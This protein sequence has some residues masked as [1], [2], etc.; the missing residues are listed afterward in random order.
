MRKTPPQ[1]SITLQVRIR[2]FDN[3]FLR[4]RDSRKHLRYLE[5]KKALAPEEKKDLADLQRYDTY[6]DWH[7]EDAEQETGYP[8]LRGTLLRV[9]ALR[10]LRRFL[11]QC[12][13]NSRKLIE[14]CCSGERRPASEKD[15]CTRHH[16]C[17]PD[18]TVGDRKKSDSGQSAADEQNNICSP[19][20]PC[21]LCQVTGNYDATRVHGS[22][23]FNP[24]ADPVSVEF[25]RH[26]SPVQ[27]NGFN[28]HEVLRNRVRNHYDPRNGT[29]R[30]YFECM[31]VDHYQCADFFG[32]ITINLDRGYVLKADAETIKM[33]LAVGL[34]GITHLAGAPCRIDIGHSDKDK[35]AGWDFTCHQSLLQQFFAT[36]VSGKPIPLAVDSPCP[37]TIDYNPL[38]RDAASSQIDVANPQPALA[39]SRKIENKALE[40]LAAVKNR[41]GEKGSGS[42]LMDVAATLK[43]IKETGINPYDLPQQK[44]RSGTTTLW[45][46]TDDDGKTLADHLGAALESL[47]KEP[48]LRNRFLDRA[49]TLLYNADPRVG[50][51]TSGGRLFRDNRLI[52]PP[53]PVP[54]VAPPP[55]GLNNWALYFITGYLE[56]KSPFHFGDTGSSLVGQTIF[57]DGE[58]RLRLP[59]TTQRGALDESLRF[60]VRGCDRDAGVD[61]GPCPVC[62]LMR[63][64][65]PEPSRLDSPEVSA[66]FRQRIRIHS[67]SGTVANLFATENGPEGVKFPFILRYDEPDVWGKDRSGHDVPCSNFSKKLKELL[68]LWQQGQCFLGGNWGT[69]NGR[70]ALMDLLI[71]KLTFDNLADYLTCRSL[72]GASVE[73]VRGFF[74][75][76]KI[77]YPSI[78]LPLAKTQLTEIEYILEFHSPLLV[79]DPASARIHDDSPDKG[80]YFKQKFIGLKEDGS[81]DYQ[82]VACLPGS[83]IRGPLSTL[84]GRSMAA[85]SDDH[86]GC[87]CVRCRIFGNETGR[88]PLRFDD[89]ECPDAPEPTLCDHVA[90]NT[91]GGSANQKKFDD[92][93]LPG[94]PG[95]GGALVFKGSMWLRGDLDSEAWNALRNAFIDLQNNME[96]IGANGSIGYGWVAKV[97]FGDNAPEKVIN[98]VRDFP[99]PWWEGR[100]LA[101]IQI[102]GPRPKNV[103]DSPSTEALAT[104]A[105]DGKATDLPLVPKAQ[106]QPGKKYW[107]KYYVPPHKTVERLSPVGHDRWHD[108]R[109]SGIIQCELE[110]KSPL[111]IPD[112]NDDRALDVPLP[113]LGDLAKSNLVASF[114]P[115]EYLDFLQRY[116]PDGQRQAWDAA[117][118]CKDGSWHLPLKKLTSEMLEQ[119]GG[120]YELM[121]RTQHKSRKFFELRDV[122]LPPASSIRGMV[123]AVLQILT[124][125]CYRNLEEKH[126]ITRRMSADEIKPEKAGSNKY[127]PGRIA[128]VEADGSVKIQKMTSLRLPLYDDPVTTNNLGTTQA[129]CHCH[130][131]YNANL[132]QRATFLNNVRRENALKN[133][134][135]IAAVAVANRTFLSKLKEKDQSKFLKIIAGQEPVYFTAD[136]IN[137]IENKK[138]KTKTV[139]EVAKL[140]DKPAGATP[141]YIKLTGPNNAM[142]KNDAT[143]QWHD[144]WSIEAL[145]ILLTDSE[146]RVSNSQTFPRPALKAAIDGRQ[147]TISKR[148]ERIFHSGDGQYTADA[149]TVGRYAETVIETKNNQEDLPP[150]FRTRLPN[151]DLNVGDLIYFK[152]LENGVTKTTHI[153]PVCISRGHDPLPL[154]KRLPGGNENLRPCSSGCLG[155]CEACDPDTFCAFFS[156]P[157]PD[158]CPTCSLLGTTSHR[159]RLRFGIPEPIFEGTKPADTCTLVTLP[160]RENP[161]YQW[162][163]PDSKAALPGRPVYVN[164]PHPEGVLPVQGIPAVHNQT[165]APLPAGRRF[166]FP[167]AFTNLKEWE[168]GILLFA[169]ELAEGCAQRLGHGKDLGLGSVQIRVY[170]ILKREQKKQDTDTS[171][172]SCLLEKGNYLGK[173]LKQLEEW[174]DAEKK[175]NLE[176][177]HINNLLHLLYIPEVVGGEEPAGMISNPSL[178]PQGNS[179]DD[180]CYIN[181]RK[182]LTSVQIQARQSTPWEPW[183]TDQSSEPCRLRE[184]RLMA[185][186]SGDSSPRRSDNNVTT[187]VSSKQIPSQK[188][189]E[190]REQC[191][192]HGTPRASDA[193]RIIETQQLLVR[194]FP[195]EWRE[196]DINALFIDY[197]VTTGKVK[198]GKESR[199]PYINVSIKA[200][201]ADKA[202]KTLNGKNIPGTELCLEVCKS[203]RYLKAEISPE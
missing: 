199:L 31:E 50:Q 21:P 38:E 188:N 3:P 141:G 143:G 52:N 160:R 118:E 8:Y 13:K 81:P 151:S 80:M 109:L 99:P 107:P 179:P 180:P 172:T 110:L 82:K 84:V 200:D 149:Q 136:P 125:S 146:C 113:S 11:H 158:L 157:F 197:T 33:F 196:Q 104:T 121:R 77:A 64:L 2:F 76:H 36:F 4:D 63:K 124:N 101:K 111:F 114:A 56:A 72:A 58:G 116:V 98:L 48:G 16:S 138:L 191:R 185:E 1:L 61:C 167:I 89:L 177:A 130:G 68:S 20:T 87:H 67:T 40:I 86:S 32:E 69:G 70:F 96:T 117:I 85:A 10:Y 127:L 129:T 142:V 153:I 134:N 47:G 102:D 103:T 123:G 59:F 112:G 79:N 74:A 37:G 88:G 45:G 53:V 95:E 201:E 161:R 152:N 174:F 71:H 137:T 90:I 92:M 12:C 106:L 203:S 176:V 150:L 181:F 120:E 30:S 49:A 28:A 46:T 39:V 9:Q 29:A 162:A 91:I 147:Y 128:A 62:T 139:I 119:L 25:S 60:F 41:V 202:I 133:N 187:K 18:Y 54:P 83:V 15:Y 57:I 171:L 7:A 122:A 100:E 19:E 43:K 168:L 132:Q 155:E 115:H 34:A 65:T 73:D 190:A 14:L 154:G 170:D 148:C 17:L 144:D 44:A 186:H 189:G 51:A 126:T 5:K 169:L 75:K 94:R 26:F 55:E 105:G 93:P 78:P 195:P 166:L 165:I 22:R 97:T 24:A 156:R 194:R 145:N 135:K 42:G 198:F 163:L 27:R 175:K 35:D 66:Q 159:G 192:D 178:E 164:H 182:K 131:H 6:L 23:R 108:G 140:T 183:N 173:G 193:N 184:K